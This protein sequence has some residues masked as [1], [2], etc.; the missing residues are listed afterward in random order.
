MKKITIEKMLKNYPF[1]HGEKEQL[2][3]DISRLIAQVV[4]SVPVEEN[5]AG[6]KTDEWLN[7]TWGQDEDCW[8]LSQVAECV[9]DY[10]CHM[11]KQIKLWKKRMLK[12]LK[13]A[14]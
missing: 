5:L 11:T 9:E 4:E 3:L 13:G 2:K 7:T 6:V 12:E 1:S 8:S 10:H 14:K